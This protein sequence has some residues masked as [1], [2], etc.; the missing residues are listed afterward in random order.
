MNKQIGKITKKVIQTLNL[1]IEEDTPIYIGD[2]NIEHIKN[3][4]IKKV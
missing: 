2:A 4:A 1:D 3:M